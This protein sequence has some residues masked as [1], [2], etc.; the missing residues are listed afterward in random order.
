MNGMTVLA[1]LAASV[2]A[3]GCEQGGGSVGSGERSISDCVAKGEALTEIWSVGNGH[4]A[5]GAMAVSDD[6]VAL[7]GADG[8]IKTWNLVSE[9]KQELLAGGAAGGGLYGGEIEGETAVVG[10]L[11]FTPDGGRII[12]GDQM[13]NVGVFE[14]D[15]TVVAGTSPGQALVHAVAAHPEGTA[16]AMVNDNFAGDIGVWYFGSNE[17]AGPLSTILWGAR[18]VAYSA[19]GERLIVAG[20]WYGLAAIEIWAPGSVDSS[21]GSWVAPNGWLESS[22]DITAMALDPSG[23]R[24]VVG[25]IDPLEPEGAGFVAVLDVDKVLAYE[26]DSW[27]KDP[28][29]VTRVVSIPAHAIRDLALQ[30]GGDV[31]VSAGADGTVRLHDGELQSQVTLALPGTAAVSFTDDGERLV[32]TGDDGTLRL[33]AC[34]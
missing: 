2:L 32:T 33:W 24:A 20:N 19:D 23:S 34:Q 16:V 26:G 11:A 27:S 6:T 30:P 29:V 9:G 7:A 21:L 8:S 25:G 10:A 5:V 4:G 13:G 22:T 28:A 3:L 12:A 15:G 1:A 14:M 18:D 31:I 17:M